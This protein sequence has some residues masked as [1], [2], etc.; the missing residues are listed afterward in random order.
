MRGRQSPRRL[1]VTCANAY[2]VPAPLNEV[3][4][5]YSLGVGEVRCPTPGERER[6]YGFAFAWG[7]TNFREDYAT[8]APLICAGALSVGSSPLPSSTAAFGCSD[9]EPSTRDDRARAANGQQ[10]SES[11]RLNH[12]E[13]DGE[14]PE[15]PHE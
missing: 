8:I 4:R 13:A 10:T 6:Y 14:K 9:T 11:A 5:A 1:A 12:A 2:G 7:S 3:A 15:K